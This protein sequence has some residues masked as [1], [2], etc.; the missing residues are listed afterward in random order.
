M[1][2]IPIIIKREYLSRVKKRSFVVMTI[3]GPLLMAC[4]MIV[5]VWIAQ[6]SDEQKTIGVVDDSGLFFKKLKET[7]NLKFDFCHDDIFTEK[8][9][10]KKRN[11]YALLHIPQN[12]ISNPRLIGLYSDGQP[13]LTVKMYI[14]NSIKEELEGMK[15]AASGIDKSVLASIE[16]N[17]RVNTFKLKEGGK[18]ESSNS[19]VNTVLAFASGILIYMFIFL[20][21]TQVMRGVIEEK[22]SRIVE[23]IVS[24]VKPFQLMMGKIIGIA[25]VGLT[26]FLLWVI[27]TFTIVS[28]AKTAFPDKFN[29]NKTEQIMANAKVNQQT[30]GNLEKTEKVQ[31]VFQA[32]GSI[33]FI[34]VIV[35]F[36]FYFLGGYLLYA[37]LFAAIGAAVDSETDTQQF[38]MPITIPLVFSF[39]MAQFVINNPE[40]PIATWLSI[41]P[42]TSPIIMMIRIPFGVPYLELFASML[43]LIIG[44]VGTTWI[45]SKIYKTGILMY[46]KKASYSELWKWMKN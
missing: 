3:L 15:L 8:D 6:I 27:L 4:I 19:E 16:T 7:D 17:V 1:N 22:I 33:N 34:G 9:N 2:K 36:L 11:Y 43:A 21:G 23:V 38:M 20:Y 25:L 31:E 42:F 10:F 46:G 40:G 41:I 24:S 39:V 14:E 35:M 28:F 26:Q 18:E 29:F 37:A 30:L 45:A 5:P 44:F 13:S 32:V 12:V